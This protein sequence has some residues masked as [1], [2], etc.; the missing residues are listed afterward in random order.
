MNI[1]I[2]TIVIIVFELALRW[3]FWW[4]TP[5]SI[6]SNFLDL[7]TISKGIVERAFLVMALL[8]DYPHALTVFSALKLGTR[9]KRDDSTEKSKPDEMNFNDFYLIG[10]FISVM[11]AIGYVSFYK[12]LFAY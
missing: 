2:F 1:L 4:I 10:N 7:R 3:L 5:K 11:V 6:K 9:L 8:N 12:Q